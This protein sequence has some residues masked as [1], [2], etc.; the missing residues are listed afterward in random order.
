MPL[1]IGEDIRPDAGVDEHIPPPS[2]EKKNHD[3]M[4]ENNL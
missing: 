3:F 2:Y 1:G 4:I